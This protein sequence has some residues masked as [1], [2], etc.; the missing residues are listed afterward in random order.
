M[1]WWPLLALGVSGCQGNGSYA[2][3]VPL[4]ELN[5]TSP[6]YGEFVGDGPVLVQGTVSHPA[7]AVYVEGLQ[8]PVD[9]NGAF[10]VQVPID[11]AY[12]NVDVEADLV[13][14]LERRRVPVF[15]R[16]DPM[17]TWP[18]GL[19]ARLTPDGLE[20][21]GE[22]FG[23]MIDDLAWSQGLGDILPDIDT[24][25]LVLKPSG[26]SHDPT[27][28]VLE[29][30][31]DGIDLA[32]GLR[33]ITI[34]MNLTIG[35]WAAP[36]SIGYEEINIGAL[37]VPTIDAAGI[38]SFDLTE[39]TVE[40]SDGIVE[41]DNVDQALFGLVLDGIGLLTGGI[42]ELLGDLIVGA[43]GGIPLGGP[44]AFDTDLMGTAIS[45]R[46]AELYGDLDGLGAGLGLGIDEPA[47]LGPLEMPTPG[48]LRRTDLALGIHEGLFQF[49]LGS[50][51]LDM[52]TQN[53][54]LGGIFGEVLGV[55]ILALPGGDS[56]PDVDGWCVSFAPGEARVARLQEGTEPLAV[57]YLP[58][59][60]LN[61]GYQQGSTYCE[62]W[63]EASLALELGLGVKEGT[64]LD[65]EIEVPDGAVLYYGAEYY[66]EEEVVEALGGFLDSVMGL[67]GSQ[68]QFDLADIIDPSALGTD[69]PGLENISP[70]IV[71][72]TKLLDE[73]G[74][75][76][77]GVYA[78]SLGLWE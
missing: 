23:V 61:V 8:V 12:F 40:M 45:I 17:E 50:E 21:L 71:G 78:I 58:D 28:V 37:A 35:D 67:V 9:R 46:L 54:E 32:I 53:I 59:L 3:D 6:T 1:H 70:E 72:S 36:I 69:I 42:G 76:P 29:P 19:T 31:E 14:Q 43:I 41:I 16:H 56:A 60:L 49:F 22:G 44:I 18:G 64:A 10:S 27:V 26:V 39:S 55:A 7:A 57:V 30:A 25:F 33:E 38:I 24:G 75:H 52:L 15:D 20:K 5:L 4:L 47:S 34:D 62:P 68:F 74:E 11:H 77:E 73:D 48:A 2:L 66:E 51:L 65:L 13:G 63:L